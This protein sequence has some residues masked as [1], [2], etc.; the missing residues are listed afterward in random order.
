MTV[1]T[2]LP[3]EQQNAALAAFVSCVVARL[4]PTLRCHTGK[5]N[6]GGEYELLVGGRGMSG[7]IHEDIEA[8]LA[9]ATQHGGRA[10]V[11]PEDLDDDERRGRLCIVWPGRAPDGPDPSSE[12]DAQAA[13]GRRKPRAG[14][15][16]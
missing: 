15:A 1:S 3:T 14:A 5:W 10:F 7:I 2:E 9:I 16:T 13:Q 4:N 8:V 11:T 6:G 12:H